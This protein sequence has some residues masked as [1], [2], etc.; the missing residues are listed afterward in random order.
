MAHLK[1]A[2][3]VYEYIGGAFRKAGEDEQV[4]PKLRAANIM[5]QVHYTDPD[6]SLTIKFTDP[7]EVIEG[8]DDP[9]ADIHMKTTDK[10]GA[11]AA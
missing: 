9:S 2:D 5:L 4:G 8:G 6:A 7:Y 1:D 11:S 3:E 10:A